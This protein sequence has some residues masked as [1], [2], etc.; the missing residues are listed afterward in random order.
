MNLA[1]NV[2][3][4]AHC[5]FLGYRDA[6]DNNCAYGKNGFGFNASGENLAFGIN[7]RF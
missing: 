1:K 7:Y 6:D 3:F 2:D 4:V 5:G